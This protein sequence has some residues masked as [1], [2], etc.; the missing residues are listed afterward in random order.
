M[1][2]PQRHHNATTTPP[3]PLSLHHPHRSR[4]SAPRDLAP[5]NTPCACLSACL[6][7]PCRLPVAA[8]PHLPRTTSGLLSGRLDQRQ[9]CLQVHDVAGRDVRPSDTL[10]LADA[11]G[12]WCVCWCGLLQC[13]LHYTVASNGKTAEPVVG[14]TGGGVVE[15]AL[16]CRL[17]HTRSTLLQQL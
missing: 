8:P 16:L 3:L 17:R 7:L 12:N 2:T 4:C 15:F 10:S 5:A 11:L 14:V 9:A 1:C 13:W 6:C